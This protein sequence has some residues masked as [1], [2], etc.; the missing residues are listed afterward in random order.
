MISIF[1][2]S[3]QWWRY[4]RLQLGIQIG[5]IILWARLT[6]GTYP[7][8]RSKLN[9]RWSGKRGKIEFD[10]KIK[11]KSG[12]RSLFGL[13]SYFNAKRVHQWFSDDHGSATG[14]KFKIWNFI[15]RK[16][17]SYS[18][19]SKGIYALLLVMYL[20]FK[21]PLIVDKDE[22]DRSLGAIMS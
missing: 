22:S 20:D 2:I 6:Q 16:C 19:D 11:I 17:K 14:L 8:Y 1:R 21:N 4:I 7:H 3:R 12:N 9:Q 15:T 13:S 5:Q 10:P 18:T